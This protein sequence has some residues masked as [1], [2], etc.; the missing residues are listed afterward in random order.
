MSSYTKFENIYEQNYISYILGDTMNL[1]RK[2][3]TYSYKT[4]QTEGKSP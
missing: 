2:T 3:G 4:H 1:Q